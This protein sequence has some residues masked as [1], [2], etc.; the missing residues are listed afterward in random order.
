[1][2]DQ[3]AVKK[4]TRNQTKLVINEVSSKAMSALLY[5]GNTRDSRAQAKLTMECLMESFVKLGF[6]HDY[7]IICDESNNPP[8]VIHQEKVGLDVYF[9]FKK[10][11]NWIQLESKAQAKPMVEPKLQ[12]VPEI[13]ADTNFEMIKK[14]ATNGT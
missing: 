14:G 3:K 4:L 2:T 7:R 8:E 6:I 12:V 1:L 5:V 11:S 13:P 9:L 10:S